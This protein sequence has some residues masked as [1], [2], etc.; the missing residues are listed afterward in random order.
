[1]KELRYRNQ[2]KDTADNLVYWADLL[3]YNPNNFMGCVNLSNIADWMR[4]E[5]GR[6]QDLLEE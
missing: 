6:I 2:L 4:N 5:A 3:V 1:M